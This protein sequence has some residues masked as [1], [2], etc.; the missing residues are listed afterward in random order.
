MILASRAK[1]GRRKSAFK[2]SI[3]CSSVRRI[4]PG[5]HTDTKNFSRPAVR[6]GLPSVHD[7]HFQMGRGAKGRAFDAALGIHPVFLLGSDGKGAKLA[8]R[9]EDA[10][11]VFKSSFDGV[12]NAEI[13]RSRLTCLDVE[14]LVMA[15]RA[16]HILLGF[17]VVVA[18]GRFF[19][20]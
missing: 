10:S 17:L 6:I 16:D 11:H 14:W 15:G 7:G 4:I 18:A 1:R 12:G 3:L 13:Q 2:P 19:E 8:D 9:A 5:P 20:V